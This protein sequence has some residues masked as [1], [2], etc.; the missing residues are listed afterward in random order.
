[1]HNGGE[2]E[3]R[4]YAVSHADGRE[5][6]RIGAGE[7]SQSSVGELAHRSSAIYA[8]DRL[9]NTGSLARCGTMRCNGSVCILTGCIRGSVATF[10]PIFRAASSCVAL[11]PSTRPHLL[12]LPSHSYL[13]HPRLSPSVPLTRIPSIA[14]FREFV[15][16][17]EKGKKISRLYVSGDRILR[18]N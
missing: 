6:G 4:G 7:A 13:L 9:K 14:R 2:R 8:S 11:R 17:S 12:V 3:S 18:C 1:M 10:R 16:N 15:T 5:S